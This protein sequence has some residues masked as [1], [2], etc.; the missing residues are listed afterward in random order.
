MTERGKTELTK[1]AREESIFR[2]RGLNVLLGKQSDY[3]TLHTFPS[4][5][6]IGINS[7]CFVA[8]SKGLPTL[9]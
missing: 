1:G 2:Q 6:T 5:A 7:M 9:G 4:V 8:F 3:C